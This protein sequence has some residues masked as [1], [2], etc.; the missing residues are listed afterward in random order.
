MVPANRMFQAPLA[1]SCSEAKHVAPTGLASS[2]KL[3]FYKHDVP[4]ALKR[5][6]NGG[7]EMVANLDFC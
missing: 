4:T 6:K 1:A 7:I 5:V 2:L 3:L